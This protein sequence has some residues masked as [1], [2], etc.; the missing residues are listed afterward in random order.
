MPEVFVGGEFGVNA[1]GLEDDADVAAQGS[2]LPN[3]VEA[4]DRGAAGSRDHECGK[5][6]E[7]SGLA[8]AVWAEKAEEF[9]GTNVEG[10][11]VKRSAVLIAMDEVANGNDGDGL[12]GLFG[13]LGRGSEV[14][15]G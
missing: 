4:G 11:A 3:S 7:E 13:R 5:N 1:L 9:G 2:G 15:G 8:A 6:P 10:N 12:A 14:D